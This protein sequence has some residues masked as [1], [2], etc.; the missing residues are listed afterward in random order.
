MLSKLFKGNIQIVKSVNT[1]QDSIEI[2]CAPLVKNKSIEPRYIQAIIDSTNELG[3]YYVLGPKIA[4]PHASPDSG[5]NK[6]SL[7]MLIV[8]DGVNY[9]CQGNDPIHLI[10]ILAATDNSSH[11]KTM[12]DLA[13]LFMDEGSVQK[14]IDADNEFDILAVLNNF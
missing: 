1:W 3:P 11:V 8:K 14:I 6:L 10:V 12:G 5:V 9:N 13:E 4:M 7:S 2:A